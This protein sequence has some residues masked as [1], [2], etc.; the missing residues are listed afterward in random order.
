VLL[1]LFGELH[2]LCR[3]WQGAYGLCNGG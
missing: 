1:T 3:R 2:W